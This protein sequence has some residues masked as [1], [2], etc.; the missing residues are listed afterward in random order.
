MKLK[1][2]LKM[3]DYV[4]ENYVEKALSKSDKKENIAV[5]EVKEEI[6]LDVFEKL[7]D[8]LAVL[9]DKDT[10]INNKTKKP[11]NQS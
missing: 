2:S 9:T 11:S 10:K 1:D 7:N 3:L 4:R 5:A 6:K 8:S